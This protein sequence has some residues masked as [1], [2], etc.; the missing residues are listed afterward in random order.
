MRLYFANLIDIVL[1]CQTCT[2]RRVACVH[3]FTD[4]EGLFGMSMIP[5]MVVSL[6]V[7]NDLHVSNANL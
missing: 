6:L 4:F 3:D 7:H 2:N 1:S 5:A